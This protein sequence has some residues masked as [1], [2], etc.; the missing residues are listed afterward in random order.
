[1]SHRVDFKNASFLRHLCCAFFVTAVVFSGAAGVR[2]GWLY[3]LND[4]MSGSRIYGFQVDEKTGALTPL[5]GFPINAGLGGNN[6]IVS[7]RMVVDAANERLYVIND[8]SDTIS[9]Y[10]IDTS[11]G[12]LKEMPFSPIELGA[13]NWNTIAVHPSGSPLI[14]GN[15]S[16][17]GGAGVRSFVITET[18]ATPAPGNPYPTT[19]TT[20]FSSEFS[21]DGQYRHFGF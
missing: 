7:E 20:A 21:P 13:G 11:T 12:A 16:S 5:S 1:M 19:G 3:V 4:D 2:A 6:S 9:A 18:T 15:G 8:T 10:S 14:V 17:T